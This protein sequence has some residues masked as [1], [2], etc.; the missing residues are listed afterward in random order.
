MFSRKYL[1]LMTDFSYILYE[2]YGHKSFCYVNRLE[3]RIPLWAYCKLCV[4]FTVCPSST[5]HL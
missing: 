5:T 1:T 2:W 4:W 3:W